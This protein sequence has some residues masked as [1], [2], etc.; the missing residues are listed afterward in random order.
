LAAL[1]TNLFVRLLTQD[2]PALVRKA[3]SYVLANAPVW[4]PIPVVVEA[5]HVLARLYG[6]EKPAMLAML[7]AATN[8]RQF[9]F[10]DQPAVASAAEL[11]SRTKAG[12]VDCLNIELARVHGKAPL[13]TF[14][15]D[16]ARL[17]GAARP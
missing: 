16:A 13:A 5:Y 1:D 15:K 14:D 9:N 4:I 11:W 12:F 6:W 8:S 7:R 3:E 10:Q 2:D 17:P